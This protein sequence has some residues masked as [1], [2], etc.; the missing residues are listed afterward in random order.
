MGFGGGEVSTTEVLW[1]TNGPSSPVALLGSKSGGNDSGERAAPPTP[2]C[3]DPSADP[4]RH[5]PCSA[6]H[7]RRC[8][9]REPKSSAWHAPPLL[10]C[11]RVAMSKRCQTAAA[12]GLPQSIRST[13]ALRRS[14]PKRRR[15]CWSSSQVVLSLFSCFYFYLLVFFLS[16]FIMLRVTLTL[17][18]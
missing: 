4:R 9:H 7:P 10:H 3:W 18:S 12:P 8:R 16:E 15:P 17:D 13:V 1:E 6:T 5:S 2:P 11:S 14:V